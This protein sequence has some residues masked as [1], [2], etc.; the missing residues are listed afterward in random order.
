MSRSSRGFALILVIWALVLLAS[1][2]TG[3]A[4][5]I[6]HEIR[7]AGDLASLARAEATATAALH[8]TV[9]LLGAAEPDERWQAEAG[10]RDIPWPDAAIGVRVRSESGRIDIN[11]APHELLLGL[12]AQFHPLETA[13]ALVDALVDW[14]DADDEP[15]PAGA[16]REAYLRAGYAYGP[17]NAPF[18]SVN[19]LS[20][21]LGFDGQ[22]RDALRPYLTV[23]SRRPRINLLGADLVVLSSVPGVDPA[24]ASSLI[25]Q[26]ERVLAEGGRMD[27]ALLR[28]GRQ[29][30]ESRPNDRLLSIDIDVRLDDGF[31]RRERAVVQLNRAQGYTL[32]A[33][34]VLPA[35]LE[36]EDARP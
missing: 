32:L 10:L 34:E 26:R 15:G 6:R 5:A 18:N 13:E 27:L 21:V 12:V 30:L 3:F 20:R 36:S 17:A 31:R 2:A 33:R 28:N 11:R 16:E 22:I 14:R 25:A 1:L 19:E 8:A 9:R 23:H 24:T 35:A 7:V 29:Y 4:F